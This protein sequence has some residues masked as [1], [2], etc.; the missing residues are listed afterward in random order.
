[1]KKILIPFFLI[2]YSLVC[3]INAQ[4]DY[5]FNCP[6]LS[7][8]QGAPF[9]QTGGKYKPSSNL[10]GQYFRVLVVFVQFE[11]DNRPNDD[12]SPGQLPNWADDFI[13]S[14]TLSEYTDMT[15]SDYWHEMSMGNYD[16]IGDVYPQ[17]VILP[18]ESYYYQ[19]NKNYSHCNRDVLTQIDPYVN[20]SLYDNWKLVSGQFI[21][22]PGNSDNLVDMILMI[23]RNPSEDPNPAWFGGGYGNF[24]GISMLGFSPEFITNDLNSV[25]QTIKVNGGLGSSGSGLTIRTGLSGHYNVMGIC[26]HEFGHYLF[27]YDHISWGGIMGGSTYALSGW[28]RERLGYVAYTIVYQDNFSITLS[29]FI[30]TGNILKIPIP[31]TNPNSPNFFLVENHQRLSHYDQIT[32]GGSLNGQFVLETTVGTGIYITLNYNADVFEQL[33]VYPKVADGDF[34]WQYDG[35]FYAGPGFY[36]GKPWEG[37]VPKTKRVA[38]NRLSGKNDRMPRNIFTGIVIGQLNGVI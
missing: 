9:S 27:G 20:F 2:L 35:D 8:E 34:D 12:W 5:P 15:I 21:F 23:Y 16:F 10:P 1:M 28:E 24:S 6:I 11:G 36:Q 29:D 38:I 37:W 17:L 18:P 31:I 33:E 32:Q 3:G 19:N 30:T 14:Q 25:G 26:N 13:N 4:T 7:P 22:S